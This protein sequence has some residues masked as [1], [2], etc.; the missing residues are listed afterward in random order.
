MGI[1]ARDL[2]AAASAV[3]SLTWKQAS[4]EILIALVQ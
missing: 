2:P 4:L 3:S 1:A